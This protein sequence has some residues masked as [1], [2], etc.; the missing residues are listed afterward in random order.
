MAVLSPDSAMVQREDWQSL[1]HLSNYYGNVEKIKVVRGRGRGVTKCRGVMTEES[2][3][4]ADSGGSQVSRLSRHRRVAIAHCSSMPHSVAYTPRLPDR[5][6][7]MSLASSRVCSHHPNRAGH[8]R[9]AQKALPDS[10]VTAAYQM[11]LRSCQL[12][13]RREIFQS[14]TR[15]ETICECR[16]KTETLRELDTCPTELPRPHLVILKSMLTS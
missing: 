3:L 5:G 8:A 13:C 14:L 11:S 6:A 9:Q 4:V 15:A 12:G 2:T 16:I 7:K 10:S 1:R